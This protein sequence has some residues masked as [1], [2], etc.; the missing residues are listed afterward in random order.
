M[1]VSPSLSVL[2][3][4]TPA[5]CLYDEF[6]FVMIKDVVHFFLCVCLS[7]SKGDWRYFTCYV[8]RF[9]VGRGVRP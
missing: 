4:L 7:A 9:T 5:I 6:S 8:N 2:S 1:A 3:K